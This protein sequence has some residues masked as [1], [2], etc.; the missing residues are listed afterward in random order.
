[1]CGADGWMARKRELAAR[2]KDSYAASILWIGGRKHESGLGV[3]ELSCDSRHKLGRNTQRI[4][5]HCELVST[6]DVVGEDVGGEVAGMHGREEG[7]GS[8]G[9]AHE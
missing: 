4:G 5:E 1:M 7:L 3:I 9:I 8:R 6:E 2:G